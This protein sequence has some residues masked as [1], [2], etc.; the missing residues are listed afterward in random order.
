MAVAVG[1]ACRQGWIGDEGVCETGPVVN[2]LAAGDVSVVLAGGR[3][4]VVV[5]GSSRRAVA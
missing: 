1:K 3:D 2:G 4:A 5:A